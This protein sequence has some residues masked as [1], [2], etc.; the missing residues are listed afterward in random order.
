M[1]QS[2]VIRLPA[3]EAPSTYTYRLCM[4]GGWIDIDMARVVRL[5]RVLHSQRN[6]N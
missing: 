4:A 6:N 3:K 5:S 1:P 2:Y